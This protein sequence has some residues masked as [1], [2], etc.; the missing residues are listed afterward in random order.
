[1]L[2]SKLQILQ[3]FQFSLAQWNVGGLNL[4]HQQRWMGQDALAL[5]SLAQ[6]RNIRHAEMPL[7]RLHPLLWKRINTPFL[8]VLKKQPDQDS[9]HE[10]MLELAQIALLDDAVHILAVVLV[11]G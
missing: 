8:T 10:G 9:L 7:L 2:D 3:C 4:D 11:D 5:R 6:N 1:M